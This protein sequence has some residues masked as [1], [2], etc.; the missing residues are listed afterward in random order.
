MGLTFATAGMFA[1]PVFFAI[2]GWVL[3]A[4]SPV[5]SSS[6][7]WDRIVRVG[8]PLIVWTVV[9]VLLDWQQG[10]GDPLRTV[11][12]ALVGHPAYSHLWFLY[13]YLALVLVVG[14]ATLLLRRQL[15][16][17]GLT[18]LVAV[19][20]IGSVPSLLALRGADPTTYF[21]LP[22]W[23][24]TYAFLGAVLLLEGDG[25]ARL[26][27]VGA[28]LLLTGTVGTMLVAVRHGSWPM[29]PTY[30]S[31]TVLASAIGVLLIVRGVHVNVKYASTI[32]TLGRASVGVYF[33]HILVL[34]I[35]EKALER[36]GVTVGGS[37]A[38][39][40][41]PVLIILT[42]A[43]SAALAVAWSRIPGMRRWLG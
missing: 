17:R 4:R 34:T 25:D 15:S 29:I 31:L 18:L 12:G 22:I 11:E 41:V 30:G 7:L 43:G 3:F 23:V 42:F 36:A 26:R 1:V 13:T 28:A 20:L 39:W 19:G 16:G 10:T 40:M 38:A 8:T 27:P 37:M 6:D 14:V 9:Y 21:R 2:T 5:G 32:R 24:L 33:V 35:L